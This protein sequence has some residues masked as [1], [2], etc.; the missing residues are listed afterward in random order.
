MLHGDTLV[1]DILT[2]KKQSGKACCRTLDCMMKRDN[3]YTYQSLKEMA[4]CG[5]T[6]R[7]WCVKLAENLKRVKERSSRSRYSKLVKRPF[8]SYQRRTAPGTP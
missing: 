4:Q 6:W 2:G 1:K 5:T 8:P 3:S 7:N